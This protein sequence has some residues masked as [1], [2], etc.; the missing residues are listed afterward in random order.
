M[1]MKKMTL[2]MMMLLT[3]MVAAIM[4][5]VPAESLALKLALAPARASDWSQATK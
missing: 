2:V 3:I 4:L 1:M 5:V